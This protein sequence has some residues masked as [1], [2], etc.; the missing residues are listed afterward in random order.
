MRWARLV[1]VMVLAV[2]WTSAAAA[3]CAWVL[4]VHRSTWNT[5]GKSSERW[6]IEKAFL[7]L[8]DCKQG[9]KEAWE[10]LIAWI[11]EH[12]KPI[13]LMGTAISTSKVE[14]V[15]DDEIRTS[16][17]VGSATSGTTTRFHCLPDTIDPREKKG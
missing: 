12:S 6:D 15:Q 4:W 11:E 13:D 14:K 7:S 5:S 2:G 8:E 17:T 16:T 10:D 3:E 1:L 9:K